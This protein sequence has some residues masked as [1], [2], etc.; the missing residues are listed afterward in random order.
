MIEQK[1]NDPA[2]PTRLIEKDA[3]MESGLK[4]V[5]E[6]ASAQIPVEEDKISKTYPTLHTDVQASG[7]PEHLQTV[8]AR[9]GF[10]LTGD[11][12]IDLGFDFKLYPGSVEAT[13]HRLITFTLAVEGNDTETLRMP[14]L[15]TFPEF[16]QDP[17]LNFDPDNPASN[18]GPLPELSINGNQQESG[19]PTVESQYDTVISLANYFKGS[20]PP[21]SA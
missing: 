18:F 21:P 2:L 3:Q 6:L 16:L 1:S 15:A 20:T 12:R 4:L 13:T 11:T 19:F 8:L 14:I 17:T 10:D 7:L 9:A 5:E